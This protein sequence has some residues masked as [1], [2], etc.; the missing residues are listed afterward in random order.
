MGDISTHAYFILYLKKSVIVSSM[1][2]FIQFHAIFW[3]IVFH[4]KQKP[5][6]AST[7]LRPIT[8]KGTIHVLKKRV[9][10]Q[11]LCS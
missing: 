3:T 5:T 2:L 4:V 10:A 8:L 1:P 9:R 11:W 7:L 6:A